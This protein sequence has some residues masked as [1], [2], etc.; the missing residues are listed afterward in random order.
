[1][2]DADSDSENVEIMKELKHELKLARA[3]KKDAF[4]NWKVVTE[5]EEARR[6]LLDIA[7]ESDDGLKIDNCSSS[8]SQNESETNEDL[9]SNIISPENY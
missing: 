4:Q 8:I 9:A 1:M 7:D 2:E 6:S 3:E 5:A